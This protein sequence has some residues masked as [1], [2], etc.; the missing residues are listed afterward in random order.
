LASV[1]DDDEYAPRLA[2]EIPEWELE[3]MVRESLSGWRPD[4]RERLIA[5]LDERIAAHEAAKGKLQ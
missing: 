4:I 3:E 2:S 1:T 5:W